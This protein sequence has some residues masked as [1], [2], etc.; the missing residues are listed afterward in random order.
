MFTKPIL[1]VGICALLAACSHPE[2]HSSNDFAN[3][4]R[5]VSAAKREVL[6][7]ADSFPIGEVFAPQELMNGLDL[8]QRYLAKASVA[9]SYDLDGLQVTKQQLLDSN[10]LIQSWLSDTSRPLPLQA[11]QIKGDDDR[12]NLQYT[13]YYVPIMQVRHVA[14][15]QYR[16]PLY[17][18]PTLFTDTP[19][20]DRRQIDFEGALQGQGL[21]IAY[22]DSLIDNFFLQ[23]QGSGVVQYED[24]HR[25]LLSWGGVNGHPYRSLGK[26]LIEDGE[27]AKESISAQAI[28]TWLLAHPEQQEDVL[29]HNPSYLFFVE[30]QDKPIGAANV[31][32]T[33][34]AS[35]AVD[36]AYIPLGAVVLGQI[37]I[38][39]QNG[40]LV[41]HELRLLLA[42]DKGGAIKGPGHVDLY[43]G[44]G[45][46]AHHE[47]GQLKHYGKLWLLLPPPA[48]LPSS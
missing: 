41:R 44:I 14:D 15:E 6:Y 34:Y 38:L 11:F 35:I 47:A 18:K 12:G 9:E 20:P 17:R 26:K 29:S 4:G 19:L 10:A 45:E 33:P 2:I 40:E 31:P 27:I 5:D 3:N 22:S 46:Q 16:Y 28:K 39:D 13:G 1:L 42:Q 24:G 21:E 23:V 37:P 48:P 36:P 32:L 25:R 8:S 30:G 43:H 7:Q